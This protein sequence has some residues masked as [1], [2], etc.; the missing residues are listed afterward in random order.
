[1]SD[2]D[3]RRADFDW[4]DYRRACDWDATD[5][6]NVAHEVVDSHVGDG[7]TATAIRWRDSD[8]REEALTYADLASESNR[9]ANALEGLD[10]SEGDRVVTYLPRIPKHYAVLL[11]TLKVGGIFGAINERYGVDGLE[12]RLGDSR[13]SVVVTTPANLE[14]VRDATA[15]AGSGAEVVTI[16]DAGAGADGTDATETDATTYTDLVADAST[17]YDVTQMAPDDPAFLY[18]TS[19]TTGPA[20]GVVHGHRLVLNL[21]AMADAPIGLQED[22]LFWCTSDLGWLTGLIPLGAL[23]HGIPAFVYDGE[24]DPADWVDILDSHPISVLFSVPTAYRMLKERD[25]LFSDASLS[26]RTA[27]SVGEPLNPAVVDW[28]R[29]RLGSPVLDNYG[30]S[31]AFGGVLTNFPWDSWE[32]RPGS[33]G[34]T[35]L[36]VDVELRD[37][38]DGTPVETGEA[39]EIAVADYPGLFLGYWEREAETDETLDDGWLLTGDLA[40]RDEAGYVWFQGR[41]DDVIL[42]SGYRIGPFDIESTLVDHDAVAE[43]AAVPTPDDTRGNVVKAVVVLSEGAEPSP[44][45]RDDLAAYVKEHLAAHEYPRQFEFVD[46]L[47]KTVTGKIRRAELRE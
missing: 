40:E 44:D 17:R 20:K 43:A 3:R 5:R 31:E 23:F 38:A 6:L 28:A 30:T 11:G 46:E 13:A 8:G 39:G 36:G 9:V 25:D 27:L 29:E 7:E 32:V 24:F 21:A 14:T 16:A 34:R 12:H 42:S 15:A 2:Y 37:R 22:D 18:Y 10:V 35:N 45:L 4:D 1:M 26:I 33:M 19:G 41:A 47:P